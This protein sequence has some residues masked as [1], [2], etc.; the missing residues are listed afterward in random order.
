MA[1]AT[2][3]LKSRLRDFDWITLG[4]VLLVTVMLTTLSVLRYTAYDARMFD[5]GNM[6]QAIW[7]GTQGRPLEFSYRGQTTSRLAMHVELI[8]FLLSPLYAAFPSPVTLLVAQAL[9]FAAGSI[10]LYRLVYRRIGNRNAARLVTLIYMTFP[11]AQTAVLFDLHGDTLAMPLLLF[12]L[13]AL[14]RRAWRAYAVSILLALSCKVYIAA[15]VCAL[16]AFLVLK[17]SRKVGVLTLVAGFVWGAVVFLGVRPL[18]AAPESISQQTSAIGY[19]KFY[20]GELLSEFSKSWLLRVGHGLAVF[21]PVI[22]VALYVP[23]W[24]ALALVVA[25]PVLLSSGP[26][27]SFH[28]GSHHYATVVPFLIWAIVEAA[29]RLHRASLERKTPG[30]T[31]TWQTA[32]GATLAMTLLVNMQLVN[33][34]LSPGYWSSRTESGL[35]PPTYARTQRDAL[36]DRWLAQN[37]P[38]EAGL[39]TSP[40]LAPHLA[41]RFELHIAYPPDGTT[42]P[43]LA[44]LFARVDYVVLD[45]LLDYIECERG[46][47]PVGDV[48]YDWE[49][50]MA[51]LNRQDYG[52]VAAQDGL[53]L[54]ERRVVGITDTAWEDHVLLQAVTHAPA[55]ILPAPQAEFAGAIGL[56]EASIT[57]L[58]DRR[59]LLRYTWLALDGIASQPQLFAVTHLEAENARILHVP[60]IT[61]YPTTV[62]TPGELITETFEVQFPADIPSGQ[63]TLTVGWYD[64]TQAFAFLT[65]EQ[66]RVGAEV[67]VGQIIIP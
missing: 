20:F 11:I 44:Q 12:A 63:Y 18:F 55:E 51:A 43:D 32:L 45:G 28:Y 16:G 17:G 21:A 64:S 37:V 24:I 49:I 3:Q 19:A 46:E 47:E 23:E 62:W 34:P 61:M 22:P 42:P 10:P 50:A 29:S 57:P 9:L 39:V 54:L 2:Q 30:K 14:D 26:G 7:S 38:A 58:E 66:S 6:A 59:V 15:P 40:L 52:L 67:P 36:K 25:S 5:L 31:V 8:Y 53:L 41:N 33:T 13:E 4:C 27:P 60:T 35:F 1:S 65:D 48:T 56:V